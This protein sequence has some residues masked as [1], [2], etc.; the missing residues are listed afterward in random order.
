MIVNG[1]EYH[2][3]DH[4]KERIQERNINLKDMERA[5]KNEPVFNGNLLEYVGDKIRLFVSLND[6]IV[7]VYEEERSRRA[8]IQKHQK[9]R[10]DSRRKRGL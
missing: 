6:T 2:F 3:T 8:F 4:V 10:R 7:T 9:K 5:L 1:R